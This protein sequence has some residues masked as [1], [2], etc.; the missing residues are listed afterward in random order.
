MPSSKRRIY[1]TVSEKIDTQLQRL[2]E[3]DGSSVA[4]VALAPL[5]RAI[6]LEEDE[7]LLDVTKERQK[8]KETYLSAKRIWR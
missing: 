8:P 3:R 2:A 5:S 1:L 4:T 6:E 7:W